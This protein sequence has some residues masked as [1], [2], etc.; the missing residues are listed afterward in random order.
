MIVKPSDKIKEILGNRK[1]ICSATKGISTGFECL[2]E[3]LL[4]QKTYLLLCTGNGGMGKSEIIDAIALNTA[5]SDGW[6]WTFYSPENFPISLHMQKHLERY[7]GKGF[8]QMT[9]KEIQEGIAT[10]DRFFTWLEPPEDKYTV[11]YLLSKVLQSKEQFGCDA[12]VLDPWNEIDH[13]N[14]AALRDDQYLSQILTKIRKFNRKHDLLGCIVIHPKGL[15]RNKDGDFPV[16]TLTDC[17]GGIMWRNKADFGL[18][19]HRHD[20]S[21]NEMT[22]YVQKVKFKHQGHVGHLDL[23]YQKASGRFKGKS[24][25]AYLLPTDAEAPF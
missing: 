9:P 2:D 16:P 11:E 22:V 23:D 4:L 5:L 18:C 6:K 13:S 24:D 7:L 20:M 17:H 14:Y 15:M 12:Y 21:K 8:W 10:L 19:C 3:L 25:K 1:E